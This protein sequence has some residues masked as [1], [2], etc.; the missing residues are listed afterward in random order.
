MAKA[1]KKASKK[2]KA[3]KARKALPA[4][5]GKKAAAKKRAAKKGATKTKRMVKKAGKAFEEGCKES[6][7]KVTQKGC[8]E[9]AGTGK[10]IRKQNDQDARGNVARNEPPSYRQPP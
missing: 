5:A 7:A 6:R 1:G 10:E 9:G 3:K 2:R 4:R 8:E